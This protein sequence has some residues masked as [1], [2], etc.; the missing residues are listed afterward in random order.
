MSER[1]DNLCTRCA[2]QK[3][4]GQMFCRANWQHLGRRHNELSCLTWYESLLIARIH[5]VISV[6]TLTG[7]GQMCYAG[8]ITNYFQKIL[9]WHHGLP[10]VFG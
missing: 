6:L 8:H 9:E 7:S 1:Q 5:A 2:N 10:T 4:Y 3:K